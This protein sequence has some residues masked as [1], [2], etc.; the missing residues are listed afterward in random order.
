MERL[1]SRY[2]FY[3]K[4]GY[5]AH[6]KTELRKALT[7]IIPYSDIQTEGEKISVV[8]PDMTPKANYAT[9]MK[10]I[11]LAIQTFEQVNRQFLMKTC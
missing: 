7:G 9:R 3:P 4:D 5:H 8:L 6:V 2:S 10:A 1:N 11:N